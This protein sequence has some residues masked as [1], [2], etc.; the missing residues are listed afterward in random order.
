LERPL[1]TSCLSLYFDFLSHFFKIDD[2]EPHRSGL[3]NLNQQP[4]L[5]HKLH[6]NSLPLR[7]DI[8]KPLILRSQS[9]QVRSKWHEAQTVRLV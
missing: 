4:N 3:V 9:V 2:V 5:G 1:N 8:S 7:F 6:S